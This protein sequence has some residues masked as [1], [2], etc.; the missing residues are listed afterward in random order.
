MDKALTP[1]FDQ[2]PIIELVLGVQF[3]PLLEMSA[4]HYGLYWQ[5]IGRHE[6]PFASDEPKLDPQFELF[7]A[8]AR[9]APK[10]V[11]LRFQQG[12]RSG[13][14]TLQ[15]ESRDCM[16]QLQDTRFISNWRRALSDGPAKYPS[17]TKLIA[18]FDRKL[19]HFD[20]FVADNKLGSLEPNQW[21]ITYVDA[22][23]QGELWQTPAD[24]H[25]VLPGLF[26]QLSPVED[27]R[28]NLELRAANWSLEIKPQIG[29]LHISAQVGFIGEQR[30]CALL[31]TM[32]ARGPIANSCLKSVR[33]G[34]D[35]GHKIAFKHF[36]K[37]V[38]PQ[39]QDSWRTKS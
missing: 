34:L 17:Y 30:Q 1:K 6:W 23:P 11:Q 32:T 4:G 21:E 15:N 25:K 39:V 24:W 18:D 19:E 16:V 22:F 2:P 35:V 3:N 20:K 13:R 31:L 33:E 26:G 36:L 27:D 28:L 37:M 14:F 5:S 9:L 12:F 8:P 38:D 29:R 7:D 10:Q